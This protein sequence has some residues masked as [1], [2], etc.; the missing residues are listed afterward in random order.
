MNLVIRVPNFEANTFKTR[1]FEL[2]FEEKLGE[3]EKYPPN[4]VEENTKRKKYIIRIAGIDFLLM[5]QMQSDIQKSVKNKT[6]P[7]EKISEEQSDAY[8]KL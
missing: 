5:E 8:K 1:K 7:R 2:C 4:V 6:I 3:E